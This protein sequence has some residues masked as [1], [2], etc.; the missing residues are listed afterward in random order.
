VRTLL[1]RDP[2]SRRCFQLDVEEERILAVRPA[3]LETDLWIA[4]GF[5]DIQVNGFGGIDFNDLPLQPERVLQL[6]KALATRGTTTFL[7]TIITANEEELQ[8]RL[9]SVARARAAYPQVFHAVP[10]IHLEGPYISPVDGYRGAHPL[11]AVRPPSL[12]EFDR[13]QKAARG[14]IRV[15]TLSPRWPASAEF[16]QSLVKRGVIVALGHTDASPEQIHRAAT[17]GAS[18]ST[19]LG[20]GIAAMLPRH[21]N[22]IWSQLAEDS[23]S[24][25]F[26]ADGIH[27][28]GET[29]RAMMRSKGV[30]RSILISDS[31]TLAGCSPGHY[32]SHIGGDV[33]VHDDGSIRMPES[34]LLA[35]SGISLFDA[36]T[37]LPTLTGCSVGEA[38]Q[39]A[40]RNPAAHLKLERG[41]LEPG[42]AA[43]IILFRWDARESSM[44]LTE[45]LV[46][47]RPVAN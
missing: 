34:G 28:D 21:P 16:I 19:H 23:L 39:M 35:G 27:L 37:R 24:A 22:P 10:G 32:Q 3:T 33:V 13:L 15:V 47:G 45:V 25:S 40:T 2:L 46:Q 4:P 31:V 17:S 41:A 5:V 36:V 6:T 8:K 44:E 14:L 11:A 20:N 30:D 43:D 26:I 7:P 38:I 9:E 42:F 29:L 18:L 1:G 12:D